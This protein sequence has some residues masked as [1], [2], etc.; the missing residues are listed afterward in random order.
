VAGPALL[1]LLMRISH[2]MYSGRAVCLTSSTLSNEQ[3]RGGRACEP[4][5]ATIGIRQSKAGEFDC[6]N[7]PP[8]HEPKFSF[9]H[10]RRARVLTRA[11]VLPS[12]RRIASANMINLAVRN[13]PSIPLRLVSNPHLPAHKAFCNLDIILGRSANHA[14]EFALQGFQPIPSGE[15]PS[16][17]TAR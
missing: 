11:W 12:S 3:E 13:L 1:K 14:A 15:V 2:P 7:A 6:V 8:N 4:L 10:Y 9:L 17:Y 16:S 5:R